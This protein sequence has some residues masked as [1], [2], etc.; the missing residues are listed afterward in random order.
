ML[1]NML[2]KLVIPFDITAIAIKVIVENFY[3]LSHVCKGTSFLNVSATFID[4]TDPSDLLK[5]ENVWRNTFTTTSLFEINI[6][7][8]V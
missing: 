3:I 2:N 7:D 8:S 6:E 1:N 4:K 5:H